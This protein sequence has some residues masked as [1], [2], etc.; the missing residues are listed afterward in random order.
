MSFQWCFKWCMI[1]FDALHSNNKWQSTERWGS[2]LV[3]QG[4]YNPVEPHNWR[5][6]RK[7]YILTIDDETNYGKRSSRTLIHSFLLFAGI[8]KFT[9]NSKLYKKYSTWPG[10]VHI[11]CLIFFPA[12][13][14]LCMMKV[15]LQQAIINLSGILYFIRYLL[16]NS[17]IHTC[18]KY[19]N[20]EYTW[21]WEDV[22]EDVLIRFLI[23]TL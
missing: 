15:I 3:S 12:N 13:Q 11:K 20:I 4:M 2:L 5:I 9:F 17:G 19:T 10:L 8:F 23:S 14:F 18:C 16:Q 21:S 7:N 22:M 6:T 1:Q